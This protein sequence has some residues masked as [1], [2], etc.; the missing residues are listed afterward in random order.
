MLPTLG[1]DLRA[2]NLNT[3]S[4]DLDWRKW[5]NESKGENPFTAQI[6]PRKEERSKAQKKG[7]V[8]L[9]EQNRGI[10]KYD[11]TANRFDTLIRVLGQDEEG[12]NAKQEWKERVIENMQAKINHYQETKDKFKNDLEEY[13][14]KI[15]RTASSARRQFGT[16]LKDCSD[17]VPPEDPLNYA[18]DTWDFFTESQRAQ[19]NMLSD[20]VSSMDFVIKRAQWRKGLVEDQGEAA[21]EELVFTLKQ[22]KCDY[23]DQRVLLN[24]LAMT[25][26]S[27]INGGTAKDLTFSITGEPGTGKTRLA[28]DIAKIIGISGILVFPDAVLAHA[29]DFIGTHVGESGVKTEGFLYGNIERTIFLDEAYALS[30]WEN[31]GLTSDDRTISQYSGEA[32]TRLIAFMSEEAGFY[33]FIAAGYK[34]EMNYDFFPANKGLERRIKTRVHIKDSEARL[35][36]IIFY[37]NLW[38]YINECK[39]TETDIFNPRNLFELQARRFLYDA[40]NVGRERKNEDNEI[41]QEY[42]NALKDK[43]EPLKAKI[44]VYKNEKTAKFFEN[45]ADSMVSLAKTTANYMRLNDLKVF[46]GTPY[47]KINLGDMWEIFKIR[48]YSISN[49]DE[50]TGILEGFVEEMQSADHSWKSTGNTDLTY[51]SEYENETNWDK[52]Q[53]LDDN[54]NETFSLDWTLSKA[55][56]KLNKEEKKAREDRRKAAQKESDKKNAAK[57][58]KHSQ[59]ELDQQVLRDQLK[60]CNEDLNELKGETSERA[61]RLANANQRK[62]QGAGPSESGSEYEPSEGGSSTSGAPT[63]VNPSRTGKGQ[64]I[65]WTA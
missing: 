9:V 37:S 30:V 21:L 10:G 32:I 64:Q 59:N 27:F 61:Q 62:K 7:R 57:Q 47:A 51:P 56:D 24:T 42:E 25:I 23:P 58:A 20:K 38:N 52:D 43:R 17:E 8:A 19:R 34:D 28:N 15:T 45:Q 22:F 13:E 14:E 54:C 36:C 44:Q 3:V 4:T 12:N 2:L 26:I 29:Q 6:V 40:V 33:G 49:A 11:M 50:V 39:G 1:L 53:R 63:R 55:L 41:E 16:K 65:L 35:L 60:K 46:C 31:D 18:H 48:A 5:E